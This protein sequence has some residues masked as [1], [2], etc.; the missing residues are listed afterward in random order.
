MAE[1]RLFVAG[2]L[3]GN[4]VVGIPA[5]H[6]SLQRDR[7]QLARVGSESLEEMADRAV[8]I[9]ERYH[10]SFVQLRSLVRERFENILADKFVAIRQIHSAKSP[11]HCGHGDGAII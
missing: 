8:D 4:R 3:A 11:R 10:H 9:I 7:M 2:G 6:E 1:Y 5:A